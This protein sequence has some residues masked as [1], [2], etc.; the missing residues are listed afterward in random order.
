MKL[1]TVAKKIIDL[2]ITNFY[3]FCSNWES[4]FY[5][6]YINWPSAILQVRVRQTKIKLLWFCNTY[7]GLDDLYTIQNE[8]PKLQ[9][10]SPAQSDH[11]NLPS[12]PYLY[13]QVRLSGC[14][15]GFSQG[16]LQV[17][18][19]L[20]SNKVAS[21]LFLLLKCWK[22][23]IANSC[24]MNNK[25]LACIIMF[26]ICIRLLQK[27]YKKIYEYYVINYYVLDLKK[28]FVL[29]SLLRMRKRRKIYVKA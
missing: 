3:V 5:G 10:D 29:W 25:Y 20:P 8:N 15:L 22:I 28:K 12:L 17:P 11:I 26:S 4:N 16:L 1:V 2:L 13:F 24:T 18:I 23:K 7:I 27:E 14:N 21:T 9:P 19:L 6:T